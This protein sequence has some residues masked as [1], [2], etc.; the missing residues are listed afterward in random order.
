MNL[1]DAAG[2][3]DADVQH[4]CHKTI[5]QEMLKSNTL[6][7]AA[8]AAGTYF[9]HTHAGEHVLLDHNPAVEAARLHPS[10]HA[11]EV[12]IATAQFA[13]DAVPHRLEVVP[14]F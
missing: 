3:N 9:G 5:L 14:A 10:L 13:E 1:A 2:A 4:V 8:V 12:H 11:G 7:I 6:K